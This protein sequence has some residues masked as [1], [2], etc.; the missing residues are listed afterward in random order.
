M[1]FETVT[2]GEGPGS[3]A[4]IENAMS[5]MD[6]LPVT[7]V[8]DARGPLRLEHLHP[9]IVVVPKPQEFT[10]ERRARPARS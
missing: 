3:G 4:A 10:D 7:M 8:P 2:S 1:S 9:G 6:G 5:F